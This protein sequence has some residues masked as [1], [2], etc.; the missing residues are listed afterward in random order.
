VLSE[1]QGYGLLHLV[2]RKTQR[3]DNV[4]Y[5]DPALRRTLDREIDRSGG[6]SRCGDEMMRVMLYE[7]AHIMQLIII[8]S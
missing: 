3:V 6:I 1:Q 5:I 8:A 7:A 4:L 2:G